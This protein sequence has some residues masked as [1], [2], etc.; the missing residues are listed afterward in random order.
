MENALRHISAFAANLTINL[1]P[2]YGIILA[3]LL[4]NEQEELNP[5]FYW[6][7]VIILLAV[8]SYP[9]IRKWMMRAEANQRA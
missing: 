8:F 9:L 6:G 3:W 5:G 7:V 4:L 2:V 1:E